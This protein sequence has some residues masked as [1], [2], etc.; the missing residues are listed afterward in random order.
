MKN[1]KPTK[2]QIVEQLFEEAK[3][4]FA[5]ERQELINKIK[6]AEEKCASL[7]VEMVK[8]GRLTVN[9]FEVERGYLGN[10]S[11][12]V[13][14]GSKTPLRKAQEELEALPTPRRFDESAARRKIAAGLDA[15]SIQEVRAFFNLPATKRKLQKILKA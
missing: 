14:C 6:A 12:S 11:V 8:D 7:I 15:E 5:K 9:H 4:T 2:R 3:V 1:T 13:D 10:L